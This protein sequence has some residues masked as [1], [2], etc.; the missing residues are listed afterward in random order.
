M[1]EMIVAGSRYVEFRWLGSLVRGKG[2]V[3]CRD[4][5]E[6]DCRLAELAPMD[7]PKAFDETP[8]IEWAEG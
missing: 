5:S 3:P 7:F 2:R 8:V 6:G 1:R 4:Q